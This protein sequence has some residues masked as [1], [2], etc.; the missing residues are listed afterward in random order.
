MISF[1]TKIKY[2][3]NTEPLDNN[4]IQEKYFEINNGSYIVQLFN[5]NILIGQIKAEQQTMGLNKNLQKKT[6]E[7]EIMN[8]S[9][10]AQHAEIYKLH[11]W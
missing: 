4:N 3:G 6:N 10:N 9:L 8:K 7:C 1:K 11:T 2:Q 5:R